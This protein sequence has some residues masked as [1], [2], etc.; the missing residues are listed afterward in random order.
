M[1]TSDYLEQLIQDRDNLVDN[2]TTM[3]IEDLTGDETFTELVPK[4]LHI[5]SGGGAQDIYRV[6]DF[7][8]LPARANE[9]DLGVVYT[10]DTRVPTEDDEILSVRFADSV[11]FSEPVDYIMADLDNRVDYSR[12]M[13]YV[14]EWQGSI[15]IEGD[16][17]FEDVHYT[18]EDSLTYVR[19]S[20]PD[21]WD[22]ENSLTWS[23][24]DSN[25]ARFLLIGG[26]L[27]DGLYTYKDGEWVAAEIGYNTKAEDLF[28]GAVALTDT[29]VVTG[30]LGDE[31]IAT[32]LLNSKQLKQICNSIGDFQPTSFDSLFEGS[33]NSKLDILKLLDTSSVTSMGSTFYMCSQ[34]TTI[35]LFDTS[36][37]TN[38]NSTFSYCESLSS[39]PLFDTSSVTSMGST[40]YMCFQLTTIPLL[41]TS[42]VTNMSSMLAHCTG[43]TSVPLLN[44]SN[45][46]DMS[47]MFTDCPQLTSIPLFDT[48]NVTNMN[49]M[50]GGCTNLATVPQLDT[51]K[52]TNMER[53]FSGCTALVTAPTL[54][55][56][57]CTW[58]EGAFTG[59]TNLQNVPV[60]DT[61]KVE[62]LIGMF[63]ACLN[64][65]QAS[66]NNI[67]LMCANAPATRMGTHNLTQIL[68][69]G[70]TIKSRY[71][72]SM[73]QG[74]SNYQAFINAGW[75]IGW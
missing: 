48:S 75:T 51:S 3:G 7:E 31:I 24:Y 59:C 8:D 6:E 43:L 63:N 52:V 10:N 69:W 47:G 27:L 61:S 70:T 73:W 49:G 60:Y 50:F 64:L 26:G 17:T 4:V 1:T 36:S 18:T 30:V 33:T 65:T 42:N 68:G 58:M 32:Q 44:T 21:R 2:L 72:A 37:V 20:G 39:I 46:T 25:A 23:E 28:S 29:G 56:E 54:N 62:S 34:L 14:D 66:C 53:I 45:V 9:G 35:P 19:D 13:I 5:P 38:M 41:D 55:T 40:F 67:L 57:S 11:T 22:F 71:P 15:M 74:L 12:V 16:G